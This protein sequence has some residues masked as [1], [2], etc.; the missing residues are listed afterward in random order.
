MRELIFHRSGVYYLQCVSMDK[1][2]FV[3]PVALICIVVYITCSVI[4]TSLQRH[5]YN[6]PIHESAIVTLVGI[7]LGYI[8]RRFDI[9]IEFSNDLFFY[10]VLPPIIFNAGFSLKRKRFFKYM[11]YILLFGVLG[12]VL[13]ITV[14]SI[15]A[16]IYTQSF[17]TEL[18]PFSAIESM[19]YGS[20]LAASDE[21]AAL[22][23]IDMEMYPKLGALMFGEGMYSL[24]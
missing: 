13:S 22:S 23:L 17:Y 12:S 18:P 7:V 4:I 21:V 10:L 24:P 16:F 5:G 8:L 19:I 20:V 14:I 11:H 3:V 15:A 2:S 9:V 1:I 6:P